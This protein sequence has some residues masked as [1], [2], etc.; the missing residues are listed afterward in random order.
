MNDDGVGDLPYEPNDGIDRV[1]WKYP[2]AKILM[3]SPAVETLHW[4]QRQFPV[5]RPTGVKDSHP[6]IGMPPIAEESS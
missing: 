5:L 3:H 1:L 4:V 2:L 6:L